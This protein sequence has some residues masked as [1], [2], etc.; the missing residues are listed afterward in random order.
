MVVADGQVGFLSEVTKFG[1][2][3]TPLALK[4]EQ[5]KRAMLY[6][7]L[8]ETYQQLYDYEAETHE[9]SEHLREHLNEYYDEFV[10]KY[11][12][13]NERKN[14]K[15]IMMD[16]NGRDALALE[17]GENGLFVKAD[18]FDHP[19]SFAVDEVTSVDTPM[20]ALS[21]SLNKYGVVDL[22]YMSSLVDMDENRLAEELK[23]SC[24]FVAVESYVHIFTKNFS[25]S[26]NCFINFSWRRC[27]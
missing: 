24:C 21:A 7:T 23:G 3:F 9:A 19:V 8:S 17:R 10:E 1:A 20:E 12:H 5:E 14:A 4:P 18:I 2:T 25:C 16:A 26:F 27:S 6:I 15:F 13:L 11:G 22:G